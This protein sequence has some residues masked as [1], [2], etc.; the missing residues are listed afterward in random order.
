MLINTEN[1][2]KCMRV[3]NDKFNYQKRILPVTVKMVPTEIDANA[4]NETTA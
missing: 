4:Q 1:R 3:K 2:T